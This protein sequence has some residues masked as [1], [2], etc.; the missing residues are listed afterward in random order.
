LA[1]SFLSSVFGASALV[2]GAGVAGAAADGAV[3]GAVDGAVEGALDVDGAGVGLGASLPQAASATVTA[4]ASSSD[5]FM[6]IS[7]L[8]LSEQ[9]LPRE[10]TGRGGILAGE[11]LSAE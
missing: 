6:K 2:D 11:M 3:E 1:S 8:R 5:L 10:T 7:F 9:V 4:A